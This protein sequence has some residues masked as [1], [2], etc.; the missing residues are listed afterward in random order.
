MFEFDEKFFVALAFVIFVAMVFKA[1]KKFIL[2]SVDTRIL[3]IKSELEEAT[4]LKNEA[5]ALL[6]KYEKEQSNSLEQVQSILAH[7]RLEAERITKEAKEILENALTKRT[8]LA[9]QKIAQAESSVLTDLRSNAL[10]ITMEAARSLILEGM[11]PEVA[12]EI[13]S[14]A[15]QDIE[16]KLH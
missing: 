16:R 12:E 6:V 13:I 9:M 14:K 1:G 8:E 7:A 15:F 2:S 4:R 11:S 5:A 10:D 3:K